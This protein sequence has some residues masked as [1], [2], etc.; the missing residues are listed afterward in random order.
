M[1]HALNYGECFYTRRGNFF[2][3]PIVVFPFSFIEATL[4][5]GFE[6]NPGQVGHE[7]ANPTSG[8]L[9]YGRCTL[10]EVA[11]VRSSRAINVRDYA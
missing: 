10:G 6:I 9:F 2:E 5:V 1:R 3:E 8:H 4:P 7:N 11:I